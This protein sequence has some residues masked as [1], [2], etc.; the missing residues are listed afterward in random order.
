MR[1]NAR[2]D[3]EHSQKLDILRKQT[4]LSVSDLMKQAIDLMYSIHQAEPK[5]RLKALLAS[6]FVGCSHGPEDLSTDYKSYLA[7]ELEKKYGT[8]R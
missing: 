4:N 2:L 8:N 7:K 3:E 6:D 1:I 5:K